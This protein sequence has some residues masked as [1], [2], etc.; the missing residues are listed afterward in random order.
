MSETAQA[1]NQ[2]RIRSAADLAAALQHGDPFVR[3]SVLRAVDRDPEA[4]LRYG[5][6]QDRDLIDELL[7]LEQRTRVGMELKLVTAVLARFH[8]PR[9]TAFLR[10]VLLRTDD[11]QTLLMAATHLSLDP[12][13]NLADDVRPL[14]LQD[15]LPHHARIAANLLV[16]LQRHGVDLQSRPVEEQLRLAL[17]TDDDLPVPPLEPL[18]LGAWVDELRGGYAELARDAAE[19]LGDEAFA[20]LAGDWHRLDPSGRVWL[21]DWAGRSHLPVGEDVVSSA[22]AGLWDRDIGEPVVALAALQVLAAGSYPA[23]AEMAAPYL[24][25]PS[26]Q[27]RRAAAE[28]GAPIR[29]FAGRLENEPDALVRVAL[30]RRWGEWAALDEVGEA[31]VPQIAE[32]LGDEDWRLRAAAT[33]ALS[34]CGPAGAD[35][36]AA[37][38]DD[39]RDEVR[40][41]AAQVLIA[42]GR[43][44]WLEEHTLG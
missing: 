19:G 28:A 16:A 13:E 37:R 21:L 41:A 33:E 27:L 20:T 44:D 36:A 6:Y 10:R 4:A 42:A 35:A 22:L 26:P 40:V 29:D 5:S 2:L 34:R 23:L 43:A 8:D 30:L 39:P 18:S 38:I 11:A 17:V 12:P 15:H 24:D 9:V 14:L 31:A 1:D 32:Y 7:A 3:L 25:H